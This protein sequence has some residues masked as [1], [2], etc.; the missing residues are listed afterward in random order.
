MN[1]SSAATALVQLF[2]PNVNR[3]TLATALKHYLKAVL[4]DQEF[5]AAC[6]QGLRAGLR[7]LEE[8]PHAQ[9]FT[10]MEALDSFAL[11]PQAISALRRVLE[12]EGGGHLL[13]SDSEFVVLYSVA[14]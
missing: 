4:N 7:D 10:F 6:S 9:A 11:S 14:C 12:E 2:G 8:K 5:A 13:S 1:E 3:S